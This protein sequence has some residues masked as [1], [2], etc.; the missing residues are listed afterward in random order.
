MKVNLSFCDSNY[1]RVPD[2]RT[3]DNRTTDNRTNLTTGDAMNIISIVYHVFIEI[4]FNFFFLF[5]E[6]V[7]EFH[8]I[9]P[10]VCETGE[11]DS[12]AKRINKKLLGM[13][14]YS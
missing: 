5:S 11:S 8:F 6:F 13:N 1:S 2:N 3:P 7:V 9:K 14:S 10:M 12:G 4:V